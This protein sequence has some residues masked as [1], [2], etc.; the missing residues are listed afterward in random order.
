LSAYFDYYRYFV[1]SDI[2]RYFRVCGGVRFFVSR[3]LGQ[4]RFWWF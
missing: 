2:N 4:G 3:A 1:V